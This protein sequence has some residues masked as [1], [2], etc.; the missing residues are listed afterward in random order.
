MPQC[1]A[2]DGGGVGEYGRGTING[3]RWRKSMDM[4]K[5]TVMGEIDPSQKG[6]FI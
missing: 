5:K 3:K 6:G 4:K 2:A 1:A